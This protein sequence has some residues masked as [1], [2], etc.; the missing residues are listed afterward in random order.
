MTATEY[1]SNPFRART[2]WI[3]ILMSGAATALLVG[4]ILTGPHQ[5]NLVI[6]NGIAR[7][8]EGAAARLWQLL[9]VLQLPVIGWFALRWLPRAPRMAIAVLACQA[10]A[11]VVAALPVFLLEM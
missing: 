3:P 9:M 5:P 7:E 10:I 8:D 4:Y 2:A 6:E 11:V 1:N